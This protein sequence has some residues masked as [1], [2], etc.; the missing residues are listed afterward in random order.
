MHRTDPWVT[1]TNEKPCMV[2]FLGIIKRLREDIRG[3]PLGLDV[4]HRDLLRELVEGR[5][6]PLHAYIV[7]APSVAG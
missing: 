2:P 7:S 4:T 6:K 5:L 3:L 1:E